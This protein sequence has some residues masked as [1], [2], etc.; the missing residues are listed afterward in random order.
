MIEIIAE[1]DWLGSVVKGIEYL[2]AR[3]ADLTPDG[4]ALLRDLAQFIATHHFYGKGVRCAQIA[5]VAARIIEGGPAE[6]QGD[7]EIDSALLP[8][9]SPS[10]S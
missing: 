7:P 2:Y 1:P 5:G 6:D 4:L 3:R 9:E 10:I 8:A